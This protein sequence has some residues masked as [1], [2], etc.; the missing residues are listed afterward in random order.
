MTIFKFM[1]DKTGHKHW[2]SKLAVAFGDQGLVVDTGP[3]E[4]VMA[5]TGDEITG[6][7]LVSNGEIGGDLM[8]IPGGKGFEPHTHKGHHILLFLNGESIV[9]LGSEIHRMTPGE[10]CVVPGDTAHGVSAV[11][12]TTLLA[13]GSPH[14]PVDAKDRM[15]V[16]GEYKAIAAKLSEQFICM[17]CSKKQS[18][19]LSE[20][21]GKDGVIRCPNMRDAG[22]CYPKI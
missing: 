7:R 13:V 6:R 4:L 12:D 11:T 3:F 2:K 20:V 21:L 17:G 1:K 8:H 14:L 16:L 10:I 5:K 9:T 22:L 18:F 19:L 15:Q